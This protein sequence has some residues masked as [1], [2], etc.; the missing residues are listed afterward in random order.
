M[1]RLPI[2]SETLD[3]AIASVE[4]DGGGIIQLPAGTFTLDASPDDT[5]YEVGGVPFQ[6]SSSIEG[7]IIV[8]KPG[9]KLRGAG[10]HAAI[11]KP[12]ATGIG[13]IAVLSPNGGGIEGMT[14]QG[15]WTARRPA[16]W[17]Q[18]HPLVPVR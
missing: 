17:P 4:A 15:L 13:G 12:S 16:I 2:T 6:P 10:R 9:V 8:L 1:M 7:M 18:W 3:D 14:V 5:Y 11:L